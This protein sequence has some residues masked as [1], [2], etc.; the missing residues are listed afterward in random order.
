MNVVSQHHG[1]KGR[2][3]QVPVAAQWLADPG[4]TKQAHT[5]GAAN[6]RKSNSK[7]AKKQQQTCEK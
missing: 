1:P 6:L 7:P 2:I 3:G 4:A 5:I